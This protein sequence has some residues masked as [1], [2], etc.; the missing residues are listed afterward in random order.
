MSDTTQ[1]DPLDSVQLNLTFTVKE[2]NI[3]I[4]LLGQLPFV[5]AVGVINAIQ[6]QCVPQIE[7]INAKEQPSEPE[8][9]A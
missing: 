6:A 7:A 2:I 9:T 5:H 4:N 1:V 3:L 8:T